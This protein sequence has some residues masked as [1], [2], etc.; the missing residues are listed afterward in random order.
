MMQPYYKKKVPKLI[1]SSVNC[2]RTRHHS[3]E[4]GQQSKT[5]TA[6]AADHPT[7]ARA[8]SAGAIQGHTPERPAYWIHTSGAGIFSYLDEDEKRYG[9]AG[10]K[11]F[12]DW[13]GIHEITSIPE[14][15]FHRN[16]DKIVFEATAN[17]PDVL[18]AAIVSPTTVYGKISD[19][20]CSI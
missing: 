18:H 5:D 14:H 3:P 11:V 1:S 8:I 6:D 13:D 9:L 7:A 16:V 19:R 12:D 15:A 4:A 10:D 17:H 20:F 2:S